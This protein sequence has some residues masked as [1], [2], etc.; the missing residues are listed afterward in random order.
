MGRVPFPLVPVDKDASPEERH[1]AF[2]AYQKELRFLRKG[3]RPR[4]VYGTLIIAVLVFVGALWLV[5]LWLV[6]NE[7]I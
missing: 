3:M 6:T 4:F 7:S 5:T 1:A 2:L